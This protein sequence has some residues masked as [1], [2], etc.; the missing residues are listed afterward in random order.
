MKP[1]EYLGTRKATKLMSLKLIIKTK[2]S[3]ICTR[4]INEFKRGY[5]NINIMKDKNGNL[6]TEPQC[7]E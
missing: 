5:I 4:D 2:I 7:F 3:E 6:L 1:V